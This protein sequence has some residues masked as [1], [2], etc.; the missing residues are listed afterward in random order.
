MQVFFFKFFEMFKKIQNGLLFIDQDTV[1]MPPWPVA[2]GDTC[3]L[4][5]LS[6][7]CKWSFLTIIF[8]GSPF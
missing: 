7:R 2:A 1:D 8:G 3:R 4:A 6:P 5:R